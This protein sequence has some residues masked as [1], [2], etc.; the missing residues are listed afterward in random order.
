[1]LK[2]LNKKPPDY[3]RAA[4]EMEWVN[5]DNLKKGHTSWW[6]QT[7]RRAKRLVHRMKVLG[8]VA[9]SA[10]V[11]LASAGGTETT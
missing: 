9:G 6:N 4:A 10:P 5:P 1:M 7:G 2:A 8:G 11:T 3:A